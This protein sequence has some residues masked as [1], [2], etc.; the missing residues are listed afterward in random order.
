[1]VRNKEKLELATRYRKQG[2]SYSE[3]AAIVGVSKGTVSRWLSKQAFSKRVRT[4]NTIRAGRD[5]ARRLSLLNKAKANERVRRYEESLKTARTEYRHYKA[6]PLFVAGLM[7]YLNASNHNQA[8][9]IRVSSLQPSVHRIFQKFALQFLGA[10]RAQIKFWI[11]LYPDQSESV[12]AREWARQLRL[13]PAQW[14]KNQVVTRKSSKQTLHFGV[15]NTIIGST[16]LKRKLELWVE[17][18]TKELKK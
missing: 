3:I 2:F 14:Y 18:A 17:L 16:L 10:D 13:Q 12:C 7:L 8:G 1:M 4:E 5:N 15:G 6:S 11:L 9:P